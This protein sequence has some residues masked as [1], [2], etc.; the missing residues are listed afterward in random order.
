MLLL[1]YCCFLIFGPF[2]SSF[3]RYW[4]MQQVLILNDLN[5]SCLCSM[6]HW[7]HAEQLPNFS[8]CLYSSF[9]NSCKA[10]C[11]KMQKVA[12]SDFL[13]CPMVSTEILWDE[14]FTKW[15]HEALMFAS[16]KV[17]MSALRLRRQLRQCLYAAWVSKSMQPTGDRGG[18][19][20]K[21]EISMESR[22]L[23]PF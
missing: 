15:F 7:K 6:A 17:G 2:L 21:K 20:K 19:P 5:V 8:L 3:F 14:L 23:T 22:K 4:Q 13:R 1:I 10:K 18:F 12:I 11:R 16:T 9:A